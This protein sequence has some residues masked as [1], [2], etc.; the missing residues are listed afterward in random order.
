MRHYLFSTLVATVI[1]ASWALAPE[2][3]LDSVSAQLDTLSSNMESTLLGK[4]DLPL[5][6]S[7]YMAFRVKNFEYYE[8]SQFQASDKART[9]VDALLQTSIVAM[10]NSYLT[11]WANLALPFDL[12]GSYTNRFSTNP[13]ANPANHEEKVLYNHNTDYYGS[14]INEEMNVG[15]DVRAGVFGAFITAGGV[16]W[17]NASPLTMWER[18]TNPRFVSQY[19]LFEDERVVST[20]YKEKTFKPV[21]EGGRAFW[22]NRSFGGLFINFYQLPYDLKLQGM[23]S[24]PS[25][26][27]PGTRDGL[28]MYGGQPG[29]LEMVGDY[30]FRG[31]LYHGRLSKE[32]LGDMTLGLN[33]MGM[34]FDDAIIYEPEFNNQFKLLGRDPSLLNTH[35]ASIDLKGNLTPKFYLMADVALSITDSVNFTYIGSASKNPSGYEKGTHTG[36]ISTPQLGVYVKAQSK[37]IENLP[38]TLEGIYLSKDF[39]SPYSMTNPSRF[40][41]W[42]KD[43]FALNS[44]SLRYSPN[45]AGANL[46]FEPVFNRGRF[47]VQYGQHRQV[48]AGQD[49]IVFNYRLN[50][51]AMWESSNSWTK[52]KPL[53]WADSG[54]GVPNGYTER[55][56][57]IYP[58]GSLG[59]KMDR[60]QG[61]LYGGTWEMWESFVA[62]E[63][64]EQVVDGEV[65]SHAKWSSFLSIDA[66]Y[67]IG[68]W[69]GTDR[70]IMMA[71]YASLSGVS[72]SIAPLAISESQK[73]MMLWSF[74][75]QFEPAI[76][77]VPTFH[78][79]GILGFET[80]RA[81]NAY[82][83]TPVSVVTTGGAA[84]GNTSVYYPMLNGHYVVEKAPINYMQTALGFGFDWDFSERAGL[85]VRYKWMTHSDEAISANDWK[86]HYIAAETKVWF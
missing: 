79:V 58:T 51:R 3:Q 63:N 31:D 72:K 24:Q 15:V 19:E 12:S 10:P 64:P 14:Y 13:T 18:E 6:V 20:Y 76:A 75:G 66:G 16:I 34:V 86:A 7:G 68:H 73:D 1:S 59:V 32:K 70:S 43:E 61:G 9:S 17:A 62:Y 53:F 30:S 69:F 38:I 83:L 41:S 84:L 37:H 45:M 82:T 23:L 50:G 67:D 47:D 49:V 60:Q 26:M 22:T 42:R 74:Y 27:D 44:G 33:Y 77:V 54:N 29:E 8:A 57:V 71:G 2:A 56:G 28:T 4:D 48:E 46:K 11:L 81:E 36:G 55:A 35:V 5:A 85:H 25:D 52:H 80:W 78:V 39:F 65:P 21:K 40:L